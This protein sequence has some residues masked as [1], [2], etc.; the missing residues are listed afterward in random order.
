MSGL[1]A[2]RAAAAALCEMHWAH[3][4]RLARPARPGRGCCPFMAVVGPGVGVAVW[5]ALRVALLCLSG[6]VCRSQ[7][8]LSGEVRRGRARG[9]S[10]I[11]VPAPSVRLFPQGPAPG[12]CCDRA[13]APSPR[14]LLCT[15]AHG[16][17]RTSEGLAPGPGRGAAS[18]TSG[19]AGPA[20]H[21]GPTCAWDGADARHPAIHAP[22]LQS[23]SN[24]SNV[25]ML[26]VT[27]VTR[28]CGQL[29]QYTEYQA[30]HVYPGGPAARAGLGAAVGEQK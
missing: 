7:C 30:S 12:R 18:R 8:T 2:P 29:R 25:M 15:C 3:L 4:A 28:F 24:F 22:R 11:S 17:V 21:H 14:T 20:C 6:L 13:A 16:S 19:L 10:L 9:S 1:R 27:H 26:S 5:V 23:T